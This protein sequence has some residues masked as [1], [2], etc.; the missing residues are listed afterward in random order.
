MLN[1]SALTVF[2]NPHSNPVNLISWG[3]MVVNPIQDDHLAPKLARP[4]DHGQKEQG[5]CDHQQK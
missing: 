5:D 4:I 1:P 2:H 3:A